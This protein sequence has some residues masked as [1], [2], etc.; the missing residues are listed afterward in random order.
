MSNVRR[1][2][3]RE[4]SPAVNM[5]AEEFLLLTPEHKDKANLIRTQKAA[6]ERRRPSASLIDQSALFDATFRVAL[7]DRVAGL[8]DENLFGRSE[9]CQQFALLLARALQFKGLSAQAVP[10]EA[11][12]FVAGSKVFSWEHAWVRI[13]AEVVDGNVDSLLENPIVPKSV[14]CRPYWGPITA[15]PLDRK[16]RPRQSSSV[17]ADPDVNDVWW[18]EL[19]AWLLGEAP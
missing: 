19:K 17:A 7:L 4:I 1:L 15:V 9:M 16:L 13:G 5:T 14:D 6:G 3:M 12:Y 11:I 2:K 10:G 8:V 18:P